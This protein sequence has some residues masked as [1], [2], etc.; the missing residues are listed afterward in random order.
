MSLILFMGLQTLRSKVSPD[1]ENKPCKS[2]KMP[3]S[4]TLLFSYYLSRV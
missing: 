4:V 3:V 2:M 1:Q